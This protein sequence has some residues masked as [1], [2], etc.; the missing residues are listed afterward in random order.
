[1]NI[2]KRN[3]VNCKR[4][5]T[6]QRFHFRKKEGALLTKLFHC[7]PA[8]NFHTMNNNYQQVSM[9]TFEADGVS[10]ASYKDPQRHIH[11]FALHAWYT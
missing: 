10:E 3:K 8:N 11:A 6:G 7:R 5:T 9:I 1:M 2:W 4:P